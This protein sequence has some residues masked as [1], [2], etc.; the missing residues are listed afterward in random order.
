MV[1]IRIVALLAACGSGIG[2]AVAETACFSAEETRDHVQKL[3][4]VALHD[5]VRSAR[6]AGHA[7]LISARLCETN[8]NMVY[9]ITMLGREGKV[10]R[11]TV[12]ARTGDLINNR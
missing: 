8:G 5:I 7:D 6:G 10:M 3:G 1:W 4:L 12:D 9:M 2:P 11:L